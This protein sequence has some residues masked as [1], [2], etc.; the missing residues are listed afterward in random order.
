MKKF[1]TLLSFLCYSITWSQAY[2]VLNDGSGTLR[3]R[4]T[5]TNPYLVLNNAHFIN[6]ASTAAFDPGSASASSGIVL[7]TGNSNTDIGGSAST[8]FSNLHIN[9]SSAEVRLQQNITATYRASLIGSSNNNVNLDDYQLTLGSNAIIT[10]EN[11]T[12][13]TGSRFYCNDDKLGTIRKDTSFTA[14]PTGQ[15]VGN[16]GVRIWAAGNL[17][18]TTTIIRG[19]DRQLSTVMGAGTSIGRYFDIIPG[20]VWNGINGGIQMFYHE[21]ELAPQSEGNLVF[22]RSP[23]YGAVTND[24]Q[25]YGFGSYAGFYAGLGIWATNDVSN[26]YVDL[27]YSSGSLGF[28]AFSR[29][30]VSDPFTD[31]L[32]VTL[33]NFTALCQ[34]G[35]VAISWS[36]ASEINSKEFV[37]QRSTDL[38]HWTFV[39]SKPGAGNSN[40]PITY[41][42]TDPRPEPGTNYYRLLQYDFNQNEPSQ[43]STVSTACGGVGTENLENLS[44]YP[45]PAT[46]YLTLEITVPNG[47]NNSILQVMDV[48]GKQVFSKNL[49]LK[50]GFNQII[51]DVSTWAPAPYTFKVSNGLRSFPVQKFVIHR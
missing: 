19:H 39:G 24:W 20:G 43:L 36:T 23:S 49:N 51:L 7:V 44:F 9:K 15:N 33:T 11:I 4:M 26:N 21:A 5:G 31:P 30:T 16:M 22:Y 14:G 50:E 38:L 6:N 47:W 28:H 10:G 25:E 29:W 32:P 34:D 37:V 27:N 13:L 42:L 41:S 45:N 40:Q 12:S 18:P 3:F 35:E 17:G 8:S 1:F 48:T 2:L 46:D